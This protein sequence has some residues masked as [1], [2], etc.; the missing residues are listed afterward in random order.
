MIHDDTLTLTTTTLDSLTFTNSSTDLL[1]PRETAQ[2]LDCLTISL[3]NGG[4]S[5][6]GVVPG[7]GRVSGLLNKRYVLVEHGDLTATERNRRVCHTADCWR[8]F[9]CIGCGACFS[10]PFVPSRLILTLSLIALLPPVS[11]VLLCPRYSLIVSD[12]RSGVHRCR[13][14]ATS[15]QTPRTAVEIGTCARGESLLALLLPLALYHPSLS[16]SALC[17]TLPCEGAIGQASGLLYTH[18][19]LHANPIP[20]PIPKREQAKRQLV[21][22]SFRACSASLP[23]HLRMRSGTW[24]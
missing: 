1:G 10:I 22:R 6:R 18:Q 9:R 11:L 3:T 19:F 13:Y 5:A 12:S 20:I 14:A 16:R 4:Q 7:S 8:Y 24:G 15:N 2:A 23:R 17:V 21:R